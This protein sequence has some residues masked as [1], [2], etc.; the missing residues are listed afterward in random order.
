[1]AAKPT[2]DDLWEE[3]QQGRI[4]ECALRDDTWHVDGLTD[5]GNGA[6]YI[7]PRPA[8]LDTLIHE[9]LHRHRPWWSETAVRRHTASL[10][11]R[12]GEDELRRWWRAY[13]RLKRAHRPVTLE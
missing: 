13:R 9:L 2:I 7:D 4:Y 6:V 8:I 11:K 12:F 1:M 10:M 5:L 3:L